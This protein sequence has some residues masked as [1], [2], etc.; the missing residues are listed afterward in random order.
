MDQIKTTVSAGIAAVLF[1]PVL[2]H[3][4]LS[5]GGTGEIGSFLNDIL[6]FINNVLVPLVFGIALLLFIYGVFVYLIQSDDEKREEG[7]QYML[8][9]VIAF[10]IMVSVWGITNLLSE[11]LGFNQE[12]LDFIPEAINR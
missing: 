8:W 4:Q 2:V 12:D 7:K 10:V 6:V 5:A 11:G 3:A 9:G 1:M